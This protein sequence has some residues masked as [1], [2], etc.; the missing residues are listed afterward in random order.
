[1][2]DEYYQ[3]WL[4]ELEKTKKDYLRSYKTCTC[5]AF[6]TVNPNLHSEWCDYFEKDKFYTDSARRKGNE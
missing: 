3:A 1:M 6:K 5:G 4:D 2:F